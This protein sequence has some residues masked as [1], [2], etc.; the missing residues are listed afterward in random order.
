[1]NQDYTSQLKLVH[2]FSNETRYAILTTLKNGE[3]NASD[4]L[5]SIGGTQSNLS[6][7]L[8]CL[9]NCG[10]IV[11]RNEGKYNFYSISNPK[12]ISLLDL[13]EETTKEFHWNN[14]DSDCLF[15]ME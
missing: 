13:I 12:I 14:Q 4:L 2:G 8:T 10:L 15:H 11:K 1:M 9:R 3:K 7:H 6:Q 5:E